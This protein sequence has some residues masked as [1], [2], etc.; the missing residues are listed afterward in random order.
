VDYKS[1]LKK[2]VL[3]NKEKPSKKSLSTLAPKRFIPKQERPYD[4][5]PD[6][7]LN[8]K[9]SST[10]LETHISPQS[11]FLQD[12]AEDKHLSKKMPQN[13]NKSLDESSQ[14]SKRIANRKQ[15]PEQKATQTD[16]KQ[17]VRTRSKEPKQTD[18]KQTARATEKEAR[19]TGS[20]RTA[21]GQQT[22]SN[23]S[24][25]NNLANTDNNNPQDLRSLVKQIANRQQGSLN[26]NHETDSKQTVNRQQ[27]CSQR[28]TKIDSKR[29]A[30]KPANVQEKPNKA[31]EVAATKENT[32]SRERIA[33]RQQT[34]SNQVVNRQQ[35]DSNQTARKNNQIKTDSTTD[36][37]Q[38]VNGKRTDSTT[39]SKKS[40]YELSGL[41]QKVINYLFKE[42]LNIG[43]NI[44]PPISNTL[45]SETLNTTIGTIKDT[46]YKL[47]KFDILKT[48]ESKTGRGGWARFAIDETIYHQLLLREKDKKWLVNGQQIDSIEIAQQAAQQIVE[49]PSSSSSF[50]VIKKNNTITKKE[51]EGEWANVQIPEVLRNVRFGP[52]LIKQVRDR[53]LMSAD[54]LQ[55]SFDAFS[56]DISNNNLIKEKRISDPVR[57]F[58]GIMNKSMVYAAS[59]NFKADEDLALE[60]NIKRLE[61]LKNEREKRE[62]ILDEVKCEEWIGSLS[63]ED[64]CRLVKTDGF[65]SLGS[66]FH[67]QLLVDHFKRAVQSG[68]S[69]NEIL[70][71]S[72]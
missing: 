3:K 7:Q 47:R 1:L 54:E 26:S 44:T 65:L 17:I 71:G 58:M 57:Y 6:S 29:T 20:K 38:I 70:S 9:D 60:E 32:L 66:S 59:T 49:A 56:F 30:K 41:Q 12:T 21:N 51:L 2:A 11:S 45:I 15:R 72:N 34:G 64:K 67:N 25:N 4:D 23:T 46:L 31:S 69:P 63:D 36:S 13:G 43:Q 24:K 61:T 35:S 39:G 5:S 68:V 33:N 27:V 48:K 40:W 22:D 10:S 62:K 52:H 55:G 19:Q 18:S 37:D 42:C 53:D 16:S 8:I 28:L 50:N 14:T